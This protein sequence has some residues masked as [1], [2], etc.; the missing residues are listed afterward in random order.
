MAYRIIESRWQSLVFKI[1][2]RAL[3]AKYRAAWEKP[4]PGKRAVGG[5]PPRTRISRADGRSEDGYAP[6]GLWRN[7]Y[8]SDWLRSLEPYQRRALRI[9]NSDYD[10]DL[11]PELDEDEDMGDDEDDVDA[12]GETEQDED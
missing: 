9:V 1:F 8:D 7:C 4:K 6:P 11:T 10:F 5:N 2:L 3:D 12:E